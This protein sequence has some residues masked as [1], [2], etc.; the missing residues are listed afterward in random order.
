MTI[1]LAFKH[2]FLSTGISLYYGT[3]KYMYIVYYISLGNF[4][5]GKKIN[6]MVLHIIF[7]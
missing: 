7:K 6:V 3:I 1:I 5:L 4:F 2:Y